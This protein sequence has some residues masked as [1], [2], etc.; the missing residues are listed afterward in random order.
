MWLMW[1]GQGRS[2]T[3][4]SSPSTRFTP[5]LSISLFLQTPPSPSAI[6]VFLYLYCK[7]S[8]NWETNVQTKTI[9]RSLLP[10]SRR[11]QHVGISALKFAI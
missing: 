10:V 3:A 8:V 6:I 2:I 9:A 1:P 11:W 7:L 4:L 5:L